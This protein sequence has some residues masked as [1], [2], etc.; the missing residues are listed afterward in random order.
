MQYAL[1]LSPSTVPSTTL[2]PKRHL[3]FMAVSSKHGPAIVIRFP[4]SSWPET[5]LMLMFGSEIKRVVTKSLSF[6][7]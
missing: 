3:M 1:V 4:P 7:D 2:S 6:Q 5:G